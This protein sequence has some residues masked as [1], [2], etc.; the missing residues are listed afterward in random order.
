MKISEISKI[1]N[2]QPSTIRYYEQ[3]GL[4]ISQRAS[5]GYREYNDASLELLKLLLYAKEL[6]FSLSEIKLF[7]KAMQGSGLEKQKLNL[8]IEKKISE[9]DQKIKDFKKFQKNLKKVL[10]SNCPFDQIYK[11]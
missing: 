9:L 1:L 7:A 10:N 3:R 11:K 4:I 2:I 6:G 5:N 8:A